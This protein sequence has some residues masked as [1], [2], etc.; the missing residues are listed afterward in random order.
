MLITHL[1]LQKLRRLHYQVVIASPEMCLEHSGFRKILSDVAFHKNISHLVADEAHCITEWGPEF[2]PAWM[3]IGTIRNL[4][5][6][7][8]PCMAMTATMGPGVLG[9]IRKVLHIDPD[10][11]LHINLG[12]DRPNITQLVVRMERDSGFEQLGFLLNRL[13]PDGSGDLPRTIVFFETRELAH[14]ASD[15]LRDQLPAQSRET[16]QR[17]AYI[18]AGRTSSGRKHTLKLFRDGRIDILCATE[19]VGMGADIPDVDLVVLFKVPSSVLVLL[20]R[21]GRAGRGRQPARAVILVEQTAFQIVKPRK[22]AKGKKSKA[23]DAPAIKE[24]IVEEL[25]I[26]NSEVTRDAY[27]E[28]NYRKKVDP[29]VRKYIEQ[30]NCRRVFLN[31]FFDNPPLPHR[32]ISTKPLCCDVC[33]CST[34]SEDACSFRDMWNKLDELA[35][36]RSAPPLDDLQEAFCLIA[37]PIEKNTKPVVSISRVKEHAE[38]TYSRLNKWREKVFEGNYYW[39]SFGP[40]GSRCRRR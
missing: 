9:T 40:D 3:Q 35:P 29:D 37:P 5:A 25:D 16:R 1:G 28:I 20:Q 23:G 15:W 7:G 24:E 11:S 21:I 17:I 13:K 30:T 38:A 39:A 18:H 34:L 2:R 14:K 22:K 6:A 33:L 10:K 19:C 27:G 4:I 26:D 12:N 36:L 8:T 32:S 31:S